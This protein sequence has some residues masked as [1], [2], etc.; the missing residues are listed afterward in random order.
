MEL[1]HFGGRVMGSDSGGRA[2]ARF[3]P[4]T[5]KMTAKPTDDS[6]R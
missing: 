2:A 6:G 1:T 4:L 5:A 3:D